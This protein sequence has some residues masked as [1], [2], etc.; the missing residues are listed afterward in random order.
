M[1]YPL[2]SYHISTIFPPHGHILL[3]R[4]IRNN[5]VCSSSD[6]FNLYYL[7]LIGFPSLFSDPIWNL[8]FWVATV[9]GS[10]E[11]HAAL[12]RRFFF[13][14]GN[15]GMVA[16]HERQT[17]RMYICHHMSRYEDTHWSVLMS[18][19]SWVH[20]SISPSR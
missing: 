8:F 15:S 1:I 10:D 18:E 4:H 20:D 19:P 3:P 2:Y 11:I 7:I 16:D 6:L 9:E 13:R 5:Q 12:Q 14:V 17:Y